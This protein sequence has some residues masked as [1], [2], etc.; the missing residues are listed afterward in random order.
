MTDACAH[1]SDETDRKGRA[2]PRWLSRMAIHLGWGPKDIP[3]RPCCASC[4]QRLRG[5]LQSAVIA[6][7][8]RRHREGA[9]LY[10]ETTPQ[11]TAGAET[12][13]DLIRQHEARRAKAAKE[14]ERLAALWDGDD[15]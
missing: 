1:C 3:G 2:V 11:C 8:A 7:Q 13:D 12:L 10:V 9:E 4:A 5:D 15:Q 6:E 14:H